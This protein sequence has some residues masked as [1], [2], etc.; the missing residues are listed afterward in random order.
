MSEE[1]KPRLGKKERIAIAICSALVIVVW[2]AYIWG[3]QIRP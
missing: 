3:W 2:T 1:K